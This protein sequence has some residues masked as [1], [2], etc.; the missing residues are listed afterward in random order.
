MLFLL[1]QL[2]AGVLGKGFKVFKSFG[3]FLTIFFLLF[4][5]RVEDF[6]R[7][8]AEKLGVRQEILNKTLWGDYYL[9]TKL[10]RIMKKA[11]EKAKKP[12]FVQLVLDNLW[13]LYD[14]IAVRKVTKSFFLTVTKKVFL[15]L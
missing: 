10:K 13:A 2:M 11:Q 14:A 4:V 12:L 1:A 5:I 15:E 9:N 8:F 7:I 3:M 6:A